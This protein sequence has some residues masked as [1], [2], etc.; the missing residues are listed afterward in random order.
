MYLKENFCPRITGNDDRKQKKMDFPTNKHQ[1]ST[2]PPEKIRLKKTH[3]KIPTPFTPGKHLTML[4]QQPFFLKMMFLFKLLIF[5]DSS[6]KKI[7]NKK[8][9]T[10]VTNGDSPNP[11]EKAA[12]FVS[13]S[14]NLRDAP[15]TSKV[16]QDNWPD[17]NSHGEFWGCFFVVSFPKI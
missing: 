8:G 16:S 11:T 1:T 12:G 10:L 6:R 2:T 3:G 4:N 9:V 15:T 14:P 5:H 13:A 7:P 17:R